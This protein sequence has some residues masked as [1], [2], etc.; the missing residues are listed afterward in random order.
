MYG[1]ASNMVRCGRDVKGVPCAGMI[2]IPLGEKGVC[3]KCGHVTGLGQY[4]AER[5][6]IV[7]KQAVVGLDR[8]R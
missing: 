7:T 2:E 3:P 1:K 8:W 6:R 5:G 4:H